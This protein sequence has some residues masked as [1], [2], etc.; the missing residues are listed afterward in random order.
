MTKADSIPA[1]TVNERVVRCPRCAQPSLY[2]PSNAYPPFCSQRCKFMDL[3][4]WAAEEFKLAAE[5][6]LDGTSSD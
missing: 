4:H 1:A 6:P 3:G 5:T 2:S